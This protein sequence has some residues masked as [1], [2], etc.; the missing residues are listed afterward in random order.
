M[1]Q[2]IRRIMDAA[3]GS[4][5]DILKLT[6]WMKSG[7]SKKTLNREWLA[8]FPGGGVAPGAPYIRLRRFAAGL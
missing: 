5:D 8:M 1:F 6:V 2:N 4:T 7:K 3:G